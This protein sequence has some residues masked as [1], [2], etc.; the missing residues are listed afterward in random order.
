MTYRPVVVA[1][2]SL[3]LLFMLTACANLGD[4]AKAV[5][6]QMPTVTVS[7]V[8]V[9]QLSFQALDLDVEL[10]VNN[11]NPL[12][13]KLAGFDYTLLINGKQLIAGKQTEG[14]EIGARNKSRV[15]VPM[16]LLFDDAKAL[17]QEFGDQDEFEYQVK[18]EAWVDLPVLGKQRFPATH[19]GMLP[20][21]K[22]PE[23]S[24]SSIKINSLSFTEA[25][26]EVGL[27]VDNPN[28]FSL[29]M[30]KLNY[31][32]SVNG[33]QWIESQAVNLLSLPEK[34]VGEVKIPVRL[35]LLKMGGALAKA[36]TQSEPLD[37]HFSGDM[38][39]DTALPMLKSM[40]L[41][42]DLKGSVSAQR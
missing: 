37:Y 5:D 30:K 26:L 2:L 22:M 31:Q 28:S 34:G 12:P 41:P 11:P 23:V 24:V 27:A 20:I 40:E 39:V 36:L 18:T 13:I 35:N 14:V 16:N 15:S 1:T 6:V 25:A 42:L 21:P 32:L 8:N 10:E 9:S 4:I 19:Q 17:F 38:L 3:L 29:D 7:S 33:Q